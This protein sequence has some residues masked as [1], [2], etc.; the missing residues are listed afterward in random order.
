MEN[1][2]VLLSWNEVNVIATTYEGDDVDPIH[3]LF[4]DVKGNVTKVGISKST[5]KWLRRKLK[6]SLQLTD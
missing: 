1:H 3:L 5:A 4:S 2:E 6:A